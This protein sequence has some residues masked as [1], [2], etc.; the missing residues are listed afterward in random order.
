MN[1]LNNIIKNGQITFKTHKLNWI[2]NKLNKK[3]NILKIILNL[4]ELVIVVLIGHR[5][6]L[7]DPN[8]KSKEKESH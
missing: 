4:I 1:C 7:M 8:N 6:Y 5:I 2:K 3:K